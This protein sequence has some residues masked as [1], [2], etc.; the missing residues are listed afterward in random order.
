MPSWNIGSCAFWWVRT[1]ACPRTNSY[2]ILNFPR[3][4][5][6]VT[7]QR[8]DDANAYGCQ[9]L[10]PSLHRVPFSPKLGAIH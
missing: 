10:S 3:N 7:S 1:I 8:A 5:L 6:N 2:L 9:N 4:F